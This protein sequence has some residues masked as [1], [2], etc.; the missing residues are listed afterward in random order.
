MAVTAS[1]SDL[2]SVKLNETVTA[3]NCPWWLIDNEVFRG[4]IRA[5]FAIGTGTP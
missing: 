2:P 1:L 5:K 4:S 3:G